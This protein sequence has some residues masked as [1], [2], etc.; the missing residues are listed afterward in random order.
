MTDPSISS[1]AP[2]VCSN[3][4]ILSKHLSY[5]SASIVPGVTKFN[6]GDRIVL[7]WKVGS[8]I[9]SEAPIYK[10]R[11]NKLNAGWV[12]TFNEYAIVSENRC[13]TIPKD[14]NKE[15]AAL[16][17]CAIT[18]GFGVIENNAKLK[19]GESIV[20]FGAGGIGLNI[21]QAA[22]LSSAWPIIAVD[23]YDSRLELAKKFGATHTIN[24]SKFDPK[25]MISKI[26]NG[27]CLET[28]VG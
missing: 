28:I 10:W 20:V 9:Q 19:I 23:L 3:I 18:T 11:G 14:T 22:S 17:G 5:I 21:I 6:E 12:T 25:E 27:I 4:P 16:F 1:P 13:T 8:G 15:L 7:H 24:S 26:M 2:I